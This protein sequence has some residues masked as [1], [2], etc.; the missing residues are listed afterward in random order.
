MLPSFANDSVMI[1]EPEWRE[2]RGKK[3]KV[4]PAL[5]RMVKPVIVQEGSSSP[6]FDQR[7]AVEIR[8]VVFLN[9]DVEVTRHARVTYEGEHYRVYGAP[10]VWRSP[11]GI[12]SHTHIDLVDWEG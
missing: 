9:P 6:T 5:G 7:D 1:A 11:S 10:H 2:E 3:V 12:A 4:Y 8:K